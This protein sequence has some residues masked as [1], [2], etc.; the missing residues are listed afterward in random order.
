[1]RISLY[2]RVSSDRQDVDLSTAAQLRALRDYAKANGHQII[3]EFVDEAESGRSINR[4]IFQE[5]ISIAR[6][7]PQPFDAVLVWKLSRFARNREDSILYKSL[8]RKHGV[9]VISIN[10]PVENTPTGKMFEGIIEVL[11]EFYSSNLM[12]VFQSRQ[13]LP[14]GWPA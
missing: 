2:T 6:R 5:M 4:P 13:T 11:D 7:R 3:R 14:S 12:S 10:E 9:Q 1:M 8:L